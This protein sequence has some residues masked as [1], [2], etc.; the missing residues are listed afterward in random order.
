[1]TEDKKIFTQGWSL[2]V[3]VVLAPFCYNLHYFLTY[4]PYAISS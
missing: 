4:S 3:V 2:I 1:M